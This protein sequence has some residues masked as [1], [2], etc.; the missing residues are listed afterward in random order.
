MH[1]GGT[2]LAGR[3]AE[4][5]RPE[6]IVA[7]LGEPPGDLG[8]RERWRA[9]AGAFESYRARWNT[10]PT[11]QVVSMSLEQISH[12]VAARALIDEVAPAAA[13]T[14]VQPPAGQAVGIDT[15]DT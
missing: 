11:D 4:I 10:E 13:R 6:H 1:I 2:E 12:Q 5:D 15:V 9:A 3:A 14:G 7:T 8:G